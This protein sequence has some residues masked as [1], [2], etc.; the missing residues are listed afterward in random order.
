MTPM[1]DCVFQLL[2]FFIIALK[3]EDIVA[4]LDVLRPGV[5]Q[6]H[7]IDDVALLQ[8]GV[9]KDGYTLNGLP[10]DYPALENKLRRLARVSR[11]QSVLFTCAPEAPHQNLVAV[12]DACSK[13]GL[14]DLSVVSP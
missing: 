11:T 14:K 4:H 8:V 12:L 1:I 6:G 13:Y 2:I 7:V 10:F 5:V 3:P 9:G